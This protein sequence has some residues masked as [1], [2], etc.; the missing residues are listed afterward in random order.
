MSDCLVSN[1]LSM[2]TT[3]TA[4]CR[5]RLIQCVGAD[6]C[7]S[8]NGRY[9]CAPTYISTKTKAI[10]AFFHTS[11]LPTALQILMGIH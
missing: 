8:T 3:N 11:K 2:A 1:T 4:L 6:S 5:M 10:H 9:I 7:R